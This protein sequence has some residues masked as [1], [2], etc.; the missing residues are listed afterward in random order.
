VFESAFRSNVT[1]DNVSTRSV[2]ASVA[3]DVYANLAS[4]QLSSVDKIQFIDGSVYESSALPDAQ[5]ALM[6]LGVFGRLPDA[7]NAGGYAQLAYQSGQLA[8]ATAMLN[9]PEGNADIAAL[10]NTEYVTR[11]YNTILDRAPESAGLSGW[12]NDLNSGLLTRADILM[13]FAT[14]PEAIA[15]DNSLFST[16]QV[17]AATPNAVEILRAY[18][19]LLGRLPEATAL[20]GNL[21][22]FQNGM[23]LQDFYADIQHSAEFASD[24]AANGGSVDGITASTPYST[25]FTALHTSAVTAYAGS[26]INATLGVSH[27]AG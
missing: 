5:T 20:S 23:T 7:L 25:V 21:T 2:D 3:P 15:Q 24:L 26:L 13:R 14:S 18:T 17:F 4:A 1:L 8:A 27:L 11:L 9:T 22:A 10:S 6:F 16:G 19:T 12:V